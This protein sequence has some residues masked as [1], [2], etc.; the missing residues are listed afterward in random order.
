[1]GTFAVQLAKAFGAQ[2]TG[3]ICL[4]QAT[5]PEAVREHAEAAGLPC[6]EVVRVAAIDVKRPDPEPTTT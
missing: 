4:Y 5:S 6:D 3:T 2:V 1:M